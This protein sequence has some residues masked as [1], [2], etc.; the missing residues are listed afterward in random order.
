MENLN[1]IIKQFPEVGEVKE[2]KALTS[3]LINQLSIP[4][5]LITYYN[6]STIRYLPTSTCYSTTSKW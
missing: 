6:V 4:K 1:Q 2:V 5:K 3:G